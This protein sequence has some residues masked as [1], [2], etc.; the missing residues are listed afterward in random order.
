[1]LVAYIITDTTSANN[2]YYDVKQYEIMREDY[3]QCKKNM[4]KQNLTCKKR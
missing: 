3:L 4:N 1:M 2:K